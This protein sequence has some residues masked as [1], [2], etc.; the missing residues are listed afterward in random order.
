MGTV[1]GID[2]GT[3]YSAVGI[4][5]ERQ[6]AG[7]LV[8]AQCPGYSILLDSLNQRI[9]PSVV[10]EDEQGNT[11]VGRRAK[12]RAGL[13][14][15]PVA[16]SKRFM[17]EDKVFPLASGRTMRP[18]EAASHVLRHLKGIAEDRLGE[19]VEEAVI[20]VPAYFV[21][22]A[23]QLTEKAGVMAG[24][25]VRQLAQEPVAAALMYCL[26]D[27]RSD[28]RIMTYD[29]GGGTFDISIVEKRGGIIAPDS[30]KSFD[31]DRY[32][33]GY[34]FDKM[35]ALWM[36]D[37]LAAQGY[38][39]RLDLD[40]PNDKAIFAALMVYA[41]EAKIALSNAEQHEILKVTTPIVD[42]S[43]NPVSI[44]LTI[45]RVEFED[46]IRTPIE[47]TIKLCHRAMEEKREERGQQPFTKD[48][49]D[50]IIMVGGSS[51]IPMVGQRLNDEFGLVPKLV[52][53]DLCV[54][55]GAAIIAGSMEMP[56]GK[57]RYIRVHP[58]PSESELDTIMVAGA[59]EAGDALQD[60][61]GMQRGIGG[62]GQV[63]QQPPGRERG[64]RVRLRGR[65]ARPQPAE[66][67]PVDGGD[68]G[69]RRD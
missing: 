43:R 11:I 50:E 48:D 12:A 44:D 64:G 9:T 20:T 56:T 59:I 62:F 61:G 25:R 14:P 52:E 68:R 28:L 19:T 37:R 1:I 57:N 24:L 46:M 3:T 2:L 53:P 55:L 60:V 27:P 69:G 26:N 15:E 38:D 41:E 10:A 34:N 42:H 18:E 63:I 47:S 51:R 58:I 8:P 54:A 45:S 49:L 33:G 35:L 13:L 30:I 17:G 7:F 6:G 23:K 66:R 16:F 36:A 67:F 31:G 29:L 39:L 40:N 32:L 5:G 4:A 21:L 22:R 65:A